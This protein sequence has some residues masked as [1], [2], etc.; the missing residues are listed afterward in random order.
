MANPARELHALFTRWLEA[1]EAT[2][3]GNFADALSIREP[4]GAAELREAYALLSS[5]DLLLHRMQAKGSDVA[6][7]IRQLDGWARVPLLIE[8]GWK[9]NA[10]PD[11]LISATRLEQIE[12]LALYL[13]GKVHSFDGADRASLAQIVAQAHEELVADESL[14]P[15]LR[16][17]LHHLLAEIRTA[18][19]DERIGRSFDFAEAC[20][21][22]WVAMRAA[23]ADSTDE[24][25][26]R[27][28]RRIGDA[29]LIGSVSSG[30][31]EAA[32]AAV[33]FAIGS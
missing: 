1:H 17:Y 4:S 31:V 19:D 5:I 3:R 13:D 28:W 23:S 30:A 33:R 29:I 10:H 27:R 2:G 21:R 32:S 26:R 12:T 7:F 9:T 8:S 24:D 14:S 15:Q 6:V 18:L 16:E 20:R 22:L 25:Q 11:H